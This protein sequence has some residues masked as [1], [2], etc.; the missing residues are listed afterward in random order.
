MTDR[1]SYGEKAMKLPERTNEAAGDYANG[2]IE[3]AKEVGVSSINL[4]SKMQ[5]TEGWQKKFLK[6][7]ILPSLQLHFIWSLDFSYSQTLSTQLHVAKIS[8]YIIQH[9]KFYMVNL[10]SAF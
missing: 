10:F 3:V 7:V 9:L 1:S 2:C 8:V 6:L 4:W 5:E